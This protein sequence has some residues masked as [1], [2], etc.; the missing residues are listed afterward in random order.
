MQDIRTCIK[1]LALIN[2]HVDFDD[3]SIHILN[4]P[5]LAYSNLSHALQVR[6]SSLEFD[7]LFESYSTMK[8]NYDF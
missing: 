6:D 5:D 8:L 7:K 4:G 3:L 2:K 1:S